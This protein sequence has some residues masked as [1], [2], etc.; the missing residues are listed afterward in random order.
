MLDN[1]LLSVAFTAAIMD[2]PPAVEQDLE[3]VLEVKIRQVQDQDQLDIV[4]LF[5][6]RF[7][8]SVLGLNKHL[9]TRCDG[10]S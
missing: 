3:Q 7:V 8:Y 5:Q 10:F 2:S 6:V 9:V 4:K 1:D